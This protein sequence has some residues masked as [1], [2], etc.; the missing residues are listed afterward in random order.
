MYGF[1]IDTV[2]DWAGA[3][4]D[5]ASD[6]YGMVS[7]QTYPYYERPPALV[8]TTQQE[9]E[10]NNTMYWIIGGAVVLLGGILLLQK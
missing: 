3:G 7:P 10:T 5:I 1:S 8:Q 2:F 6:I 9:E 4:V